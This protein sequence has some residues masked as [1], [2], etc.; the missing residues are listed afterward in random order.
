VIASRNRVQ[1][2]IGSG[3][4]CI[5]CGHFIPISSDSFF[6]SI[7]LSLDCSFQCMPSFKCKYFMQSSDQFVKVITENHYS[8]LLR[9]NRTTIKW[10]VQ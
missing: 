7:C 2:N 8:S 9:L 3:E 4:V 6:F 5:V 10:L 1:G